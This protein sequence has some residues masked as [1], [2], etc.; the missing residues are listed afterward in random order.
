MPMKSRLQRIERG[1]SDSIANRVNTEAYSRFI[2]DSRQAI[3][4]YLNGRPLSADL[5]QYENKYELPADFFKQYTD[6]ELRQLT[7]WND[8]HNQRGE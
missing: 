6:S 3:D 5:S 1:M 8:Q 4:D 7:K 2:A